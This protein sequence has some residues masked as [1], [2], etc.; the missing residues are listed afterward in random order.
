VNKG[1]ILRYIQKPWD[2][3]ML[4]HE[5]G[6]AIDLFEIKKERN[7]LVGLLFVDSPSWWH[8]GSEK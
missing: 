7:E 3:D 6:Q 2:Y 8:N 4:K 5:L 1:E